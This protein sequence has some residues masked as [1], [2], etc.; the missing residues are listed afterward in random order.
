V[1]V[2]KREKTLTLSPHG[3]A[4][5]AA[6]AVSL[7]LLALAGAR[8]A[9]AGNGE[10]IAKSSCAACHIVDSSTMRREV[11]DAPPFVVIARK[12]HFNADRLM[13]YLLEAHPRMNFVL[14]RREASDVAAYLSTLR[15]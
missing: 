2:I 13:L 9:D 7:T 1:R 11:A 14:A 3:L 10:R 5:H 15:Q 4:A 8:A 12:F 6:L